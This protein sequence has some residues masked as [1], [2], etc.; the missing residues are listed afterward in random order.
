MI[1]SQYMLSWQSSLGKIRIQAVESGITAIEFSEESSDDS[2]T[3]PSFLAEC[4][5]QLEE[6]FLGKRTTFDSLPFSFR[7]TDFQQRVW[8]AAMDI[9]FGETRS[10]G[11]LAEAI[12]EPNASRAV[13]GALHRNHIGIIVPCHRIVSADQDLGG[14]AWGDW[15]KEWLLKHERGTR[16]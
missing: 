3:T 7:G 5:R 16:S 14:Y 10:Y 8:D 1:T 9:P 2:S 11:Q 15:R 12:G 13:G 4:L 6:Y